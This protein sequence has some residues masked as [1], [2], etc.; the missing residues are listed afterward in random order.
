MAVLTLSREHQNGCVEIGQAVAG[1]MHYEFMD[2]HAVYA[3]LKDFGGKW[4]KLGEDLDEEPPTLWEK[5]D[6][7]YRGF[8]ALIESFV[9]DAALGDRV[10]ILGRGSAFLL[11]GIPQVLKVRLYAP[12]EVRVERRMR[13][14]KEDREAASAYIERTDKSRKGYIQALYG[15]DLTD[16]GNY[17]LFF[18]TAIQTYDQ[19]TRNLVEILSQW[20]RRATPEG[21]QRLEDRALVA[22][23]KAR[24]VTQ[25][26][27]FIPTLEIFTEGP[28]IVVRGVV[29]SPK[30]YKLIQDI[31]HQTVDPRPIRN[32]LRFRT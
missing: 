22:R 27:I 30:E 13:Q 4:S 18:N 17:D 7:E 26:E 28:E 1:L 15:K 9:L 32:E 16:L 10:V 25:P 8:V 21:Q 12:L 20:D 19:V 6:L 23:V 14:E 5:F 24:I 29:H 2:R 3:R 11:S 31:V